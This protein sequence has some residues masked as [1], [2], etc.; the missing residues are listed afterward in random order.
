M[1][2]SD[3]IQ[4]DPI[5]LPEPGLTTSV[6]PIPTVVPGT[7]IYQSIDKTGQRTLWVVVVLMAL[8]ALVFYTLAARAPL[9]KRVFHSLVS[10]ATTIS[11]IV[12]LALATGEGITWKHDIIRE[13]HKHVP[14]VT[15][16]YYRQVFWLRYVNWFLTEPLILSNLALLS[17][18]PGAHLLSAVVA[19]YVMLSAGLLGTFAGHTAR[20]W[21]WFT[22]S[23]IGYLTMVYHIGINGSRAAVNKDQ[24]TKRF[25]GT[26]SGVSLFVKVLYPVALAAGPLALKINLDAENVVF[27]IYDIFTQGIIGYW[28]LIAH[29]SSNGGLFVDGFWSNGLGNEG[30]IRIEEEGA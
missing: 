11:F 3:T 2:F 22:I 25:F 6:S 8:S 26:I 9:S 23:A 4:T 18:L 17:G 16:E 5:P 28:L 19:D 12:Y 20:R 27:A 15:E 1:T 13:H 24:Q 7:P 14:N 21:V 30:S 10:I 29:D